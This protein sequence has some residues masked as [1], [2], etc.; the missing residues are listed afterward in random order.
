VE[1]SGCGLLDI[2]VLSQHLCPSHTPHGLQDT[3]QRSSIC[4]TH[5]VCGTHLR[6]CHKSLA[7]QCSIIHKP[8]SQ[9]MAKHKQDYSRWKWPLLLTHIPITSIKV[10]TPILEMNKPKI[11]VS[12]AK[13]Q[14]SFNV[15]DHAYLRLHVVS[16][17]HSAF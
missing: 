7:I 12:D 5:V 1:G 16:T 2:R 3:K 11:S 9:H 6:T 14:G 13:H 10:S 4:G 17:E 15:T 8:I